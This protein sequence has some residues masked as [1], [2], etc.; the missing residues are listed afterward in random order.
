MPRIE[1]ARPDPHDALFAVDP[2][3]PRDP[4]LRQIA[5]DVLAQVKYAIAQAAADDTPGNEPLDIAARAL[6]ASRPQREREAARVQA[7]S[8]LAAPDAARMRHFGRFANLQTATYRSQG[9]AAAPKL[10]VNADAVRAALTRVATQLHPISGSPNPDVVAGAAYKTMKLFIK[11]VRCI[12]ETNGEWGSD[13]IALGGTKTNPKGETTLVNQ[14]LV[15]DDF[16]KGEVKNYG[17]N[18]VFCTWSLQTA[19]G[20]FPY[21]YSAVIAMAEKD[22]GGFHD[23]LKKLWDLVDDKVKEAVAGAVGAAAGA[24]LGSA[25]GGPIGAVV[26]ALF[27]LL[28]GWLISLF[29]NPDDLI[30]TRV[31]MM[32]LGAATKSYYDWAKLTSPEGWTH[33]LTFKGDGGHYKVDV[34][35]RVFT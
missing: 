16:D 33:T 3:M 27:G 24:A 31:T 6:V 34:A 15:H 19:A 1:V 10:S 13:E 17:F 35:Y 2:A 30:G 14:F 22:D 26:G 9:F 32:T 28:I 12:D 18:K 21:V 29:D 8:L 5:D 11:R 23:I 25:F 7:R 20:G 4:S